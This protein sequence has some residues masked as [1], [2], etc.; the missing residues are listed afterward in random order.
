MKWDLVYIKIVGLFLSQ[1]SLCGTRNQSDLCDRAHEIIF[2]VC[3]LQKRFRLS[4]II[5]FSEVISYKALIHPA[6]INY[7]D[8][9]HFRKSKH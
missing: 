1:S 9:A 8:L 6:S 7:D 2:F 3:L 4:T 5:S